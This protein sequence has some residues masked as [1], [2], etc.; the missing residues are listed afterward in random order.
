MHIKFI[1]INIIICRLGLAAAVPP[2]PPASNVTDLAGT[3]LS[4]FIL[5]LSSFGQVHEQIKRHFD[6]PNPESNANNSPEPKYS[7]GLPAGGLP[8]L[9]LSLGD[10][11]FEEITNLKP[12]SLAESGQMKGGEKNHALREAEKK[13]EV[14]LG[15]AAKQCKEGLNVEKCN[16]D[17]P[18]WWKINMSFNKDRTKEEDQEKKFISD[19]KIFCGYGG[20]PPLPAWD[21][22]KGDLKPCPKEAKYVNCTHGGFIATGHLWSYYDDERVR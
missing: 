6:G 20:Y 5:R 15:L 13:V 12:E 9:L 11:K 21:R 22:G 8:G 16:C 19:M 18:R 2:P 17:H 7:A 4:S 14:Y 10:D 1:A 3:I